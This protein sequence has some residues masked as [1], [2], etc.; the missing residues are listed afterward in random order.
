MFDGH[1]QRTRDTG[2]QMRRRGGRVEHG[3]RRGKRSRESSKAEH[4]RGDGHSSATT[5]HYINR[6]TRRP[7]APLSASEAHARAR[8][9]ATLPRG[10]GE[11][12]LRLFSKNELPSKAR[13]FFDSVSVTLV[14]RPVSSRA[15]KSTR[16]QTLTLLRRLRRCVRVK[17]LITGNTCPLCSGPLNFSTVTVHH[18]L[19]RARCVFFSVDDDL[20]GGFRERARV[21]KRGPGDVT[22]SGGMP[23]GDESRSAAASIRSWHESS[24]GPWES[25]AAWLAFPVR[26]VA[27]GSGRDACERKRG[28]GKLFNFPFRATSEKPLVFLIDTTYPAAEQAGQVARFLAVFPT[29]RARAGRP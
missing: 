28:K 24:I 18:Y 21:S 4:M 22:W 7:L 29:P 20:S 3:R 12:V 2:M 11:Q 5:W 9:I 16:H 15:V 27:V 23:T 19:N 13:P 10:N 26:P 8:A 6:H 25:P 14:R 1:C 17:S